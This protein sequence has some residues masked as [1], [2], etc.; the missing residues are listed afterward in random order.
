M[1]WTCHNKG[2]VGGN[3]A[4]TAA[5]GQ[6]EGI[7]AGV[8]QESLTVEH[9]GMELQSVSEMIGNTEGRIL[10]TDMMTMPKTSHGIDYKN[11]SADII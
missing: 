4:K 2:T 11:K 1:L 10:C 8:C 6:L 5:A 7:R 3:K 9:P